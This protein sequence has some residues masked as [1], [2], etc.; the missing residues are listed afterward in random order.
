MQ[1]ELDNDKKITTVFEKL[2]GRLVV[3]IWCECESMCPL[4]VVCMFENQSW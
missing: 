4:R 2:I 3:F 1:K